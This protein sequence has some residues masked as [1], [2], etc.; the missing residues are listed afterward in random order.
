MGYSN[1]SNLNNFEQINTLMKKFIFSLAGAMV[2]TGFAPD[3]SAIPSFSRQTN[4]TCQSCHA[5]HVPILNGFGQAFKAAGY[6]L[7]GTQGKVEGDRLSIPNTLNASMRIKARY[8]KSNGDAADN[9]NGDSTN[10]G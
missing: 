7:M 8:Q 6:P 3:A 9:F 4:M 5:Q 2:T 10:S 1:F